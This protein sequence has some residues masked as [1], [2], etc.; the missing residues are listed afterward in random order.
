MSGKVRL[1]IMASGRGS[2][3][4]SVL[5]ACRDK[6][7]NATGAVIISNN[8]FARVHE[9]AK[10]YNIPSFTITR[11]E[12]D[13]GSEFAEKL[14][15][16]FREHQVDLILLAGYM[17]KVPPALIRAYPK[18]MLN[19]HPALLPKHGGKGMYGIHVHESVIDAEDEYTGVTIHFVNEEYDEGDVLLQASGVKVKPEDTPESL[20]KRVLKVEH[21]SYPKAVQRWIETVYTGK[22]AS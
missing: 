11:D 1:G 9:V 5:R 12:F 2:N 19:I 21:E 4:E 18:A 6:Q 16:V 20:A 14:I 7:L 22:D 13:K 17:K 8:P 10:E 15:S 3:A